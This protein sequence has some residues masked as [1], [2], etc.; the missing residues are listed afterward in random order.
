MPE[1]SGDIVVQA[2][3]PV[4]FVF[5]SAPLPFPRTRGSTKPILPRLSSPRYDSLTI[6]FHPIANLSR[7]TIQ[8]RNPVFSKFLISNLILFRVSMFGFIC[9]SG[10]SPPLK[11]N[12]RA[13]Q[14]LFSFGK[15]FSPAA[16]SRCRWPL[17]GRFPG[18]SSSGCRGRNNASAAWFYHYS[19]SSPPS[20]P[21]GTF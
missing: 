20:V 21:P 16:A 3:L 11:V 8:E 18:S 15:I 1:S 9:Y 17:P 2:S 7:T 5:P 12:S 13:N 19:P 10:R 6:S 14:I 4:H